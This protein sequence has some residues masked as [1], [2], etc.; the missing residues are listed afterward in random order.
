MY[1]VRS[2]VRGY[3]ASHKRQAGLE[4][5][6][7]ATRL[8]LEVDAHRRCQQTRSLPVSD[9][10]CVGSGFV[11]PSAFVLVEPRSIFGLLNTLAHEC[12]ELGC[13]RS[14]TSKF[15]GWRLCRIVDEGRLQIFVTNRGT[16]HD[17]CMLLCCLIDCSIAFL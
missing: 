17:V 16:I 10:L 5:I 14:L 13:I 11:R 9:V 6:S 1:V 15:L 12:R 3:A 7:R 2:L 4:S 8:R